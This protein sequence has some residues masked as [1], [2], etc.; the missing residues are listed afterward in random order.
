MPKSSNDMKGC[1]LVNQ[2]RYTPPTQMLSDRRNTSE[3]G[4][5]TAACGTTYCCRNLL[6]FEPLKK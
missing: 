6:E 2:C 1:D 4:A 5:G 3:E